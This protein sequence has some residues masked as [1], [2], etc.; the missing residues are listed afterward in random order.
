MSKSLKSKLP[1]KASCPGSYV[2]SAVCLSLQLLAMEKP[3]WHMAVDLRP[4]HHHLVLFWKQANEGLSLLGLL[5][6]LRIAFTLNM[7]T[8]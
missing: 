1:R 3:I 8:L 7:P 4:L 5:S 2:N 6:S